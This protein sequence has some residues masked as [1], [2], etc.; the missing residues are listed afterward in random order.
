MAKYTEFPVDE[1]PYYDPDDKP[2]VQLTCCW[3]HVV[4]SL[5]IMEQKGLLKKEYNDYIWPTFNRMYEIISELK[6]E[7]CD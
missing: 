1:I 7:N 2:L 4:N 3:L 5:R 6:K